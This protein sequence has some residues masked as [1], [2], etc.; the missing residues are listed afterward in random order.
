MDKQVPISRRFG[1]GFGDFGSQ[2]AFFLVNTYFMIFM[3]NVMMIPANIAGAIYAIVL[4]FDAINDPIIGNLADRT[5]K[6]KFGKYRKW[7]TGF[8]VPYA[9]AMWLSFLNPGF[10]LKGQVAYALIIHMAY[11][12]FATAWQVPYGSVP[13]RMTTNPQERAILGTFRDW[14]ANFAKFLIGIICV[15]LIA[16]F[17]AGGHGSA[18]YFGMAGV[19]AV[20]CIVFC[21]IAG[22]SSK[23][24]VETGEESMAAD[25][26][27]TFLQG[28]KCVF[29]NK[30]AIAALV[31]AFMAT[32]GLNFKSAVTPYYATYVM[33]NPA[34]AGVILPL[35]FTLP[36][37]LGL[38]T[39]FVVKK[40]GIKRMFLV[41]LACMGLSGVFG[42]LGTSMVL[43]MISALLMS[44]MC[45]WVA[46]VLWGALPQLA[47]YGEV[48]SGICC[49]GSYY[50]I[51][52]FFIKASTA[53]SGLMIGW[54]LSMG[55]FDATL[56]E[57]PETLITSINLWNGLVPI[58][59]AVIGILLVSVLYKITDKDLQDAQSTLAQI[60][61]ERIAKNK[62]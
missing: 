27:V 9:V 4:I 33:G 36:L 48:Q 57:Q 54:A 45:S 59:A 24:V 55:S 34:L 11:S 52:A 60:R 31:A 44:L 19:C 12:I 29:G 3:T 6:T 62:K 43:V 42:L 20:I 41:C 58:I 56:T 49:P 23:E 1:F 13:N 22:L 25:E 17:A 28:L 37:A 15:K 32:L 10:G 51:N 7:I 2:F 38:L 14:F 39:P 40:F 16:Y 50:S 61:A 35:I 46:P 26:R 47:D 21:M 53:L 18:G 5:K 30:A 8:S